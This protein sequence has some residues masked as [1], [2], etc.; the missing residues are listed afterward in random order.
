M[1]TPSILSRGLIFTVLM[2]FAVPAWAQG[3]G[4]IGGTVMDSYG[5][6][7][8]GVTLTLTSAQ[9]GTLGANREVVSDERFI[10]A[11]TLNGLVRIEKRVIE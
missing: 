11:G 10:Y 2:A 7:L 4:G 9:G 5:A 3:V 8:P 6:V 1:A